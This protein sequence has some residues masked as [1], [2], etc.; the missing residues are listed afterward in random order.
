[1]KPASANRLQDDLGGGFG[2]IDL[3]GEI[4]RA[5]KVG[6]HFDRK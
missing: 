6:E 2:V 5:E 3:D 1:L 4:A